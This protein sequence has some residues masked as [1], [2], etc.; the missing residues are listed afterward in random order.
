MHKSHPLSYHCTVVLAHFHPI[1]KMLAIT[2]ILHIKVSGAREEVKKK[3]K[4]PTNLNTPHSLPPHWP[5]VL[6]W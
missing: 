6:S 1:L 5:Q 2:S 4:N 3:E